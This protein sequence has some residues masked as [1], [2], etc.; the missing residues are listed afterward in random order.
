M[1]PHHYYEFEQR[2]ADQQPHPYLCPLSTKQRQHS[3]VTNAHILNAMSFAPPPNNIPDPLMEKYFPGN[4]TYHADSSGFY[5]VLFLHALKIIM[6]N[7]AVKFFFCWPL[8]KPLK[9]WKD[10]PSWQFWEEGGNFCKNH[11]LSQHLSC[12]AY[13]YFYNHR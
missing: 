4:Q 8:E 9:F 2:I 10:D 3:F 7:D 11:A 12:K 13:N 5:K 6:I 1:A